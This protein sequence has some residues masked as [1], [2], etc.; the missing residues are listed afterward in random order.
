MKSTAINFASGVLIV[1]AMLTGC[2]DRRGLTD[3][4]ESFCRTLGVHLRV[5]VEDP[6][7]LHQH[8]RRGAL[9]GDASFCIRARDAD[10]EWIDQTVEQVHRHA[11]KL[12]APLPT[13]RAHLQAILALYEA[14]RAHP[15]KKR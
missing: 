14:A 13:N 10:P 2:S 5:W 3:E 15:M 8:P 7:A 1:A 6:E 9:M 12:V 4:V 11:F